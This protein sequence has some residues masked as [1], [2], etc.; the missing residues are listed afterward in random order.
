MQ[1]RETGEVPNYLSMLMDG[2][3]ESAHD[4]YCSVFTRRSKL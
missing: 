1:E 4:L 2:K 3:N